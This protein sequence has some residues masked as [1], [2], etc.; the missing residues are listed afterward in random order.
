[1]ILLWM[2]VLLV[3]SKTCK[4]ICDSGRQNQ[5][6]FIITFFCGTGF[7]IKASKTVYAFMDDGVLFKIAYGISA[8]FLIFVI[9]VSVV[10]F[11]GCLLFKRQKQIR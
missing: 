7:Y 3:F 6:L 4:V 8:Y 10:M 2:M 1:M 5:I 11:C 9:M